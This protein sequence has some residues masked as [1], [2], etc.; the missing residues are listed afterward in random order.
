MLRRAWRGVIPLALADRCGGCC[1]ND[2][3]ARLLDFSW[4]RPRGIATCARRG[5]CRARRGRELGACGRVDLGARRLRCVALRQAA[6]FAG[7]EWNLLGCACELRTS[8]RLD[9]LCIAA[10]WECRLLRLVPS[11]LDSNRRGRLVRAAFALWLR[12]SSIAVGRAGRRE[13][14]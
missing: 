9:I 10:T 8:G 6:F 4:I 11:S 13:L 14:R 3:L 12:V 7:R 1:A 2:R 5:R